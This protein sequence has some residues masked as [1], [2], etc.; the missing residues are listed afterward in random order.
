MVFITLARKAARLH[1]ETV[2][3]AWLMVTTRHRALDALKSLGR[4]RRH[5]R[6][7]AQMAEITRHSAENPKRDDTPPDWDAISPHLDMALADLS[8]SDRRAIMLRYFEDLSV[9]EVADALGIELEAAKQRVHRATVR[10]R[11]KLIGRGV[12]I[13][14]AAI[15]PIILSNA[16][17]AA[18][19]GVA[20]AVTQAGLAAATSATAAAS[21]GT[22]ISKGSALL[23]ATLKTKIIV[24]ACAAVLLSGGAAVT[25]QVTRPVKEQVV[26]LAS[27]S[28][29]GTNSVI[30]TGTLLDTK[31]ILPF[32]P[33][34]AVPTAG[35]QERFRAAYALA[36]GEVLKN[37]PM[38]FIPERQMEMDRETKQDE[39]NNPPQKLDS[40]ERLV[41]QLVGND[42]IHWLKRGSGQDN[43]GN[44]IYNVAGVKVYQVDDISIDGNASLPGDWVVRE[45]ASVEQKMAALGSIYSRVSGKPVRFEKRTVS[46]EPFVVSGTF[47]F[48]PLATA[49]DADRDVLQVGTPPATAAQP[50]PPQDVRET[51]GRVLKRLETMTQAQIIDES[52]SGNLPLKV[53][54]HY[55]S[56]SDN[57]GALTENLTKQTGLTFKRELRDTPV[58]FMVED[59]SR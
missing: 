50:Q 56:I 45:G 47:T 54:Y 2:L 46:R 58:W 22:F 11:A 32:V 29:A 37:I 21:T 57:F 18:P 8:P 14:T 34:D 59:S 28:N 9:K 4:R 39:G 7:A 30:P 24:G 5:E 10:L 51:F 38:P 40:T 6:K 15:G 42:R 27:V 25:Y 49:V 23:M 1:H 44:A 55:A 41:F 53:R 12:S 17:Q 3:S 19:A 48:T 35:W 33:S 26:P 20:A 16:V 31:K 36:D 43:L 13:A 52:H